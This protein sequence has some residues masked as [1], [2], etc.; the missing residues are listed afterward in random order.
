MT[1]RTRLL[2][3]W[4]ILMALTAAS[5]TA[6]EANVAGATSNLGLVPVAI[7]LAAG[8]FKARQILWHFLDLRRSTAVW[9][10]TFVAFLAFLCL[11]LYAAYA[12]SLVKP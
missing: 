4:T 6:A 7:V 10:G 5:L 3:T 9:K 12:A 1:P 8:L 2:L 11:I